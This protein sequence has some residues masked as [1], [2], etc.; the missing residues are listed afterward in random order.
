MQFLNGVANR[1]MNFSNSY[2]INK[3]LEI[4]KDGSIIDEKK[5]I[6]KA[7]FL[8]G[9]F[10]DTSDIVLEHPSISRKHSII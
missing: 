3:S 4:V 8:I 10:T 5:I 6:E 7:F 2:I 9:K 1:F